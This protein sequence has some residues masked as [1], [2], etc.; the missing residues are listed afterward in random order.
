MAD[1]SYEPLEVTLQRLKK[2]RLEADRL[3]QDALTALDKALT[4]P[5]ALPDIPLPADEQRVAALNQAWDLRLSPPHASGFRG[6]LA[7]FVWRI[8]A[9]YLQRQLTFNSELV[10]HINHNAAAVHTAHRATQA[11]SAAIQHH[12]ATLQQFQMQLLAFVQQ[13]TLYVDTKDRDTAGGALVRLRA[14]S[15]AAVMR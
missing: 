10:A 8:V 3:Y 5:P 4:S 7:A 2:E 11:S 12:L 9:P 13:I 6:R 14:S 1:R 15:P